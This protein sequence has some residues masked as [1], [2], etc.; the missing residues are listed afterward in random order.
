MWIR[1]S[2]AVRSSQVRI[3]EEH[4]EEWR[5]GIPLPALTPVPMWM[6]ARLRMSPAETLQDYCAASDMAEASIADVTNKVLPAS[7]PDGVSDGSRPGPSDGATGEAT[8]VTHAT[9]NTTLLS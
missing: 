7:G 3:L 2:D 5:R 9:H 8:E 4:T 6:L 1:R